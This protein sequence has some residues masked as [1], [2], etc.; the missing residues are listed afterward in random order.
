MTEAG[1]FDVGAQ[2]ERTALAWQRTAIGLLANGALLCRWSLVE[3]LPVWPAVVLTAGA[4]LALLAVV[5]AR[6]RRIVG[7]VRSGRNPI[8]RF[9]MPAVVVG[10]TAVIAL[11]VTQV[12]A[13]SA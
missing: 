6:Y 8:A 12:C 5:P 13:L 9:A 11:V 2:A 7:A 3:H 10:F 1:L 4:G